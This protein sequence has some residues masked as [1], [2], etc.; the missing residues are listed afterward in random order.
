MLLVL[1]FAVWA[2]TRV[3][4]VKAQRRAVEAIRSAGGQLWFD[5]Q[6]RDGRDVTA[7]NSWFPARIREMVGE[8]YF[9]EVTFVDLGKAN[10][11]VVC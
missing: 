11:W 3:N 6:W 4:R 9:R 2:G 7:S 5:D 8:D 1:V 10:R